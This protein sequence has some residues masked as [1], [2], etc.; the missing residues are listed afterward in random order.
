[1]ARL[2]VLS[3]GFTGL[4]YELKA[5]MTTIGRTEANSF[6]IAD[7]SVSSHH[8][9]VTLRGDGIWVKDLQSTNGSFLDGEP[10]TESLVKPGQILRL[11]EID[12]RLEVASPD[13][14]KDPSTQTRVIPQ[15]VKMSDL[16]RGRPKVTPETS[17]MF[18]KKSDKGTKVFIGITIG[19]LVLVVI[20]L[21]V[22]VMK[23]KS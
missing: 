15:G 13:Q 5:E 21:A 18:K 7:A 20:V 14:K 22:I 8:A 3:E 9:E 2:V 16:E 11:G 23:L 4:S 6:Q 19:V 1:M 12:M 10:L 17:A